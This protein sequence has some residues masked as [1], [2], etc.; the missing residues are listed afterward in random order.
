M[1]PNERRATQHDPIRG[2][3][4]R[5]G[6]IFP[7]NGVAARLWTSAH[8]ARS[9]LLAEKM[10]AVGRLTTSIAHEVNNPLNNIR[11]TAA[12]DLPHP[13]PPVSPIVSI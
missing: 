6:A 2:A 13:I 12:V 1:I 5:S 4:L 9:A 10:A 3:T 11:L 8:C 7:S